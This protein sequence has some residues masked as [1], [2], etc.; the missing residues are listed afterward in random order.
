MMM[1]ARTDVPNAHAAEDDDARRRL[2]LP[3][4][5]AVLAERAH[6]RAVGRRED[7]HLV[8]VLV[9]DEDLAAAARDALQSAVLVCHLQRLALQ[10]PERQW[11][12]QLMTK[13]LLQQAR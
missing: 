2:E 3:G 13:R 12:Q 8:D 5:R 10:Q 4:L 11:H 1:I 9:G 6:V 7:L